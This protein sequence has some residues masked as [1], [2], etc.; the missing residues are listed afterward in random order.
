MVARDHEPLAFLGATVHVTASTT[1]RGDLF[2]ADGVVTRVAPTSSDTIPDDVRTIDARGTWIVPLLVDSAVRARPRDQRGIYD[3]VPGNPA[4]FAVVREPVSEDR[5]RRV[6][7]VRPSALLAVVVAGRTE[8][9]QGEPVRPPG[10]P[11]RPGAA[12]GPEDWVGT[13]IDEG[14]AMEQH[15]LPEGRYTETR[16]GRADA[17]TGRYWVDGGR[18]TYL[19]DSGFWAFGERLD[20]VLHHAGFILH[21]GRADAEV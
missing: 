20:D 17:Y 16:N 11:T 19:D 21:R 2:T 15:L 1:V 4:T 3:L 18:I 6:L 8:V 7:V 13:W 10:A 9:W 5:I 14:A 12:D